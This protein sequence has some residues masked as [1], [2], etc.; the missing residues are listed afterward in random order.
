VEKG[1]LI[2]FRFQGERRLAVVDRPDGKKDWI[3]ID[4]AGQSH[5]LRPQ[6]IEY[7]VKGESYAVSDIP[8]F[9][10]EV[11]SY[12][13]PS[14]LEIAWELLAEE[15]EKV[16][17]E[18]LAQLLYSEKSPVLCYAAYRLL[19]D[20]KVYFKNKGDVY[21]PRSASQVNEILH[22]LEVE[23]KRDQEKQEFFTHLKEALEQK[24][25]QWSQSDRLRLEALEK[26]VLQPEQKNNTATEILECL[27]RLKTPDSA[28]ELLVELGWWSRHENLFLLRSSYPKT[29]PKKVIEV[30]QNRLIVQPPDLDENNRLDL[31][32]LKVYTIDDEST[33]EIDDGLSVEYLDGNTKGENVRLWIHIADPTRLVSPGDELDLE[34]RR[35][36]TTLYLPTGMI[37]MFPTELATG[38]MSLIQGQICPSLSFAVTL[39]EDGSINDFTIHPSL[40]KPTYRLTY[41][42]VDEMLQLGITAEPELMTLW[43]FAQ[44]RHQWRIKQGSIN[45]KMPETSIKV[46]S[47]EE[48]IISL[49]DN[50]YSRQLVAEMM[51]LAGEVAGV[52]GKTHGL[53]LP[54]RGQP[55]PE[56]PSEEELLQYP[57][58]PVRFV[59]LRRCMPR[60]EMGINPL[61]HA[62]LGLDHY[63]QVTSPIRR[64]TDLLAHFQIKAHLRGDSLPFSSDELQN[65]IYSVADS[66]YEATL[67]ERQTNRYW[68]IEYL[69]RNPDQVWQ[70]LVLRWLKEDDNLGIILLEELGLEL[71]HRFERNVILGDRLDV[72]VTRADPH[73]DEIRFREMFT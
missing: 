27:D 4:Q 49:L 22:Q 19:S 64:Y 38:P 51:I 40:I 65:I 33:E 3:V 71:P 73:R 35:R 59:H 18:G 10:K 56:L 66:A 68:S 42:D 31:T 70:G 44:K 28:F 8:S 14:G 55:Q 60:S 45:I 58:G 24:S 7:E 57:A 15:G 23:Q 13:D 67:T 50:A 1:K 36:S 12:L 32:H 20:D 11:E 63:I 43:D 25:V 62:G 34:A 69:R 26:L 9:V 16:T 46:K 61:R 21:E 52:Y 41:D 2:E 29:F 72:Q 30:T 6:R 5:K 47:D 39:H 37:S 53:P 54:F 48:I 17:P